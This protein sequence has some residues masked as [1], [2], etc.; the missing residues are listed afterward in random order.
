LHVI[1]YVIKLLK[2]VTAIQNMSNFYV[3][4]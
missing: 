3:K 1:I 4:D 2:Y